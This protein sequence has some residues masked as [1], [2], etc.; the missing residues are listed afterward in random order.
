M[1]QTEFQLN[2]DGHNCKRQA[3]RETTDAPTRFARM[4]IEQPAPVGFPEPCQIFSGDVFRA[5]DGTVRPR[6][7]ALS[8]RGIEAPKGA[9]FVTLCKIPGCV[10]HIE[11]KEK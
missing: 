4:L 10:R 8:L 3:L 7:Y 2:R 9:K 11:V 5:D 1:I 6:R